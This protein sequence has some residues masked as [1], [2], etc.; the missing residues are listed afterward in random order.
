MKATEEV[1]THQPGLSVRVQ[2]DCPK[3]FM[4]AVTHLVSTGTGFPAI[5]S[6]SVGYQMLIN[7]GYEPEDARDWNNCGCVVPHYRKPASGP[8]R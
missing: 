5:H 6:D 7:A 3:A 4:D 2:A 8:Q 1:K